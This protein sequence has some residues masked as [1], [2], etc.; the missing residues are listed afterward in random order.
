MTVRLSEYSEQFVR[1]LVQGGRFPSED[2][3]IEE[4]IRLL[5]QRYCQPTR[6]PVTEKEVQFASQHTARQVENLRRLCQKVDN[7]PSAD[8]GDGLTNRDHDRILYGQ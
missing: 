7:L 8:V 3:A 1:S 6:A 2:D 5:E 4:A